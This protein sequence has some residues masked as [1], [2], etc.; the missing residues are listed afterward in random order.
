MIKLNR[1]PEPPILVSQ[2]GHWLTSLQNSI[3]KYGSYKLIPE[4]ERE[5]LIVNYR[6]KQIQDTL[7]RSSYGKCSFCECH[8]AEGGYLQVEHFHPKSIYPDMTFDWKNLLPA[9]GPCNTSKSSHDTAI[10]PLINPYEVDPAEYFDFEG[11]SVIAKTGSNYD[12]SIRT[13][14]VFSLEG[15]RLWKPRAE[16]L[17]SLKGFAQAIEEGLRDVDEADTQAKRTRRIRR[18]NEALM[19]IESLALPSSKFS[20]FCK[21]FLEKCEVYLKAKQIVSAS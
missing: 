16:I 3:L 8:P 13:I 17:I 2:G 11:I 15:I 12:V 10:E 9:C 18:L 14:E 6:H 1:L 20:A 21:S 19:T 7:S 4:K 5:A